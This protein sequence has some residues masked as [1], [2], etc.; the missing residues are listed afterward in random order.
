MDS[1]N[2]IGTEDLVYLKRLYD[3]DK[4]FHVVTTVAIG[5]FIQR[6]ETKPEWTNIVKFWTLNDEW[7]KT[8]TFVMINSNDGHILFDTLEPNPYENL[9]KTLNLINYDKPMVFICFRD[10]FRPLVLDVIRVQNLEITFDSGTRTAHGTL[11]D[12]DINTEI[13][14][15]DGFYLDDLKQCHVEKINSMWPQRFSDSYKF[16]SNCVAQ[17]PSTGLFN[18][19]TNELVAWQ[20]MLETGA[21]GHLFI[22]NKFRRKGFATIVTL[23]QR[24][25]VKKLRNDTVGFVAHQNKA[26]QQLVKTV[27]NQWLS[28]VSFIGICPKPSRIDVPLWG[29]L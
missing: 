14:P 9:R 16:L 26:S 15:P 1:L 24:I 17:N 10:I 23:A 7:K 27:G 12:V 25:K 18:K 3:V 11:Q 5:H 4:P 19:D 29:H 21:A 2:I 20:I 22:D 6:F 13:V 8:G 28:N